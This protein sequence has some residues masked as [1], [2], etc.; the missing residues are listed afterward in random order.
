MC[1][2]NKT[3]NGEWKNNRDLKTLNY[4]PAFSPKREM[5][6]WNLSGKCPVWILTNIHL[7]SLWVYV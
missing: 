4:T 3:K 7:N 6:K 1:V 2:K 5:V